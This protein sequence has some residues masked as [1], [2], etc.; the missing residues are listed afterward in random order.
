MDFSADEQGSHH[1]CL[2]QG[3]RATTLRLRGRIEVP[4]W[5]VTAE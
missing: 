5:G 2:R 1:E 4:Y 3:N